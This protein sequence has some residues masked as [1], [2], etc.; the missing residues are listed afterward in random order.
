MSKNHL[1]SSKRHHGAPREFHSGQF[2]REQ[3]TKL[4]KEARKHPALAPQSVISPHRGDGPVPDLH[5]R[6]GWECIR[7]HYVCGSEKTM[8]EKHAR[9]KHGWVASMPKIW[10]KQSI[11]V[12]DPLY[13]TIL[14]I[15]DLLLHYQ[16]P[17]I[18]PR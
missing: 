2:T 16:I 1:Y 13:E 15:I 10:R 9:R 17:Q 6:D 3:R 12:N 5:I 8:K 11:Q 4:A 7:C 18:F 14:M